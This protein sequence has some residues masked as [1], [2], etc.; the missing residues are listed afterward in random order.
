RVARLILED[1]MEANKDYWPELDV[2]PS[3]I[4]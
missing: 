3:P 2:S 4:S 1:L